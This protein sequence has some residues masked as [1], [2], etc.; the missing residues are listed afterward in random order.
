M[1]Q[2]RSSTVTSRELLYY[3]VTA[4]IMDGVWHTLYTRREFDEYLAGGWTGRKIYAEYET[5]PEK[6]PVQN[7]PDLKE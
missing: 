3:Q 1:V 5:L 4:E 6:I 2:G 7:G